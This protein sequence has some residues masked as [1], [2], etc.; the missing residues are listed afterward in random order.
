MNYRQII[1]EAWGFTQENKKL[2]VG[3]AFVPSLLGTVVGAGYLIYQFYSFKSS[4]LFENWSESFSTVALKEIFD[5][6]R[7]NIG[8][9]VLLTVVAIIL[10]LM[11]FFLPP[12]TDGAMIQLIARKKSGQDVRMR[13]GLKYGL[14][15]FLPLFSYSL[16]NRTFNIISIFWEAAFVLRNLGPDTFEA[17]LPVLIPLIIISLLFMFMFT[18]SEYYIVIDDNHMG[19]SMA[20][21]SVL[22]FKHWGKAFMVSLLMFIIGIRILLQVVFVLLVPLAVLLG[23]FYFAASTLPDIGIWIG[24]GLGIA[25]LLFASYLGAIVHVFTTTVWVFSFL[26]LTTTPEINARGE[27]T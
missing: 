15:Y 14:N 22:V 18:F 17:L 2:I 3:Y 9:G 16:A 20:K 5:I 13:D 6:L 11:Y 12:I 19:Q 27:A 8:S 25:A 10:A 23:F 24:G 21:S 26:D 1:G 4:P 7:Q